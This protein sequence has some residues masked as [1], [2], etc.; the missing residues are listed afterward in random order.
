MANASVNTVRLIDNDGDPLDSSGAL[1]VKLVDSID[2]IDIGDVSLLLGGTAASTNVGVNTAQTLR[3]TMA[4]DD[5]LTQTLI[6]LSHANEDDGHTSA[7]KGI[8]ALG[9]RNDGL[10]TNFSGTDGDYTPIAVTDNGAV[11]VSDQYTTLT[12]HTAGT[13]A[14]TAAHYGVGALVVRNDALEAYA[15]IADGD[16]TFL[17]ANSIGGLYVTGSEVENAAV[18]SEPLLIGGRYDSS[19]RTLGDGDAGSVALNASG[20][21]LVAGT[22]DLGST[23]N[24]VL[25]AI[26]ASLTNTIEVVGDVAENANAAGNPV[27]IGGRYDS[28]ARTL[29]NTDVGALAL[30]ASG[31]VLI[32]VVDGGVLETLLDGVE[33]ILAAPAST[34]VTNAGTFAVQST[35][36]ANSGV[37]IGDVDVTSIAAGDNNIGNVDIASAL[38]A[39][40]NAIGKLAANSGV[41][42]GDVDVTSIAAGDNNIGNV[43]IASALPAG[44]NAIGKLAANDGVDIG[45]VD[46]TSISAGTNAIGKVGHDIT[47]AASSKN[48]AVGTSI[49]DLSGSNVACKRVDMMASPS[50]TGYIWVGG[51]NTAV[52]QGIRLAAGDFYSVDIDNTEDIQVIATVDAEDISYVIYT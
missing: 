40:S 14:S 15:G 22:V 43:D 10:S 26:A 21:M 37:D 32:D 23:D 1:K 50:N 36:Q 17:Q 5:A 13:V 7:D 44:S 39:G 31:H 46:V 3:V 48:S 6:A 11:F 18:Q 49:E 35:L 34:P 47:G 25:D 27:L 42:I 12:P 16:Y 29:G 19:A 2:T 28:S 24:A 45:D 30:N 33:T 8:M 4:V 41:D 52:G 9:V 20:H 38:P 51:T